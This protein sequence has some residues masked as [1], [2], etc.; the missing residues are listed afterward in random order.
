MLCIFL[1]LLGAKVVGYSLKPISKPNL[2]ELANIK[3]ILKK[4]IIAD[5]RNYKKVFNEYIFFNVFYC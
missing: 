2:F 1:N 4:S 5:V 3:K